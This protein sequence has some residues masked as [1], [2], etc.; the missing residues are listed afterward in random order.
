MTGEAMQ[1]TIDVEKLAG[2]LRYILFA[3]LIVLT[4]FLREPTANEAKEQETSDD[5]TQEAI[6]EQESD[7]S[8]APAPFALNVNEDELEKAVVLRIIDGETAELQFSKQRFEIVRLVHVDAPNEGERLYEQATQRLRELM[9]KDSVVEVEQAELA[10][11][12]EGQLLV[13]IFKDGASVNL[14]LVQEGLARIAPVV[15]PNTKYLEAFYEAESLA[16]SQN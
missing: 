5:V 13:Y 11:N 1:V 15:H 7:A 14:Q 3:L 16:Q 6:Q 9:I 2:K 4:F 8:D 10:R 12:D